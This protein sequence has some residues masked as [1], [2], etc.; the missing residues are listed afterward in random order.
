MIRFENV[1]KVYGSGASEVVALREAAFEI[2][3]GEFVCVWGASGSGK[4]TLLNIAG[5]IDSPTAGTVLVDGEDT[6]VLDGNKLADFRNRSIGYVFQSFNLIAVLSALENVMLPLLIGGTARKEA[7]ERATRL[8]VELGLA[9]EGARRPDKLSGGQRQR[10]AI[11]RA[12]VSEPKLVL[13]DEPTANLDSETSAETIELMKKMNVQRGVTFLLSTHDRDLATCA[14]RHLR[15]H[16]GTLQQTSPPQPTSVATHQTPVQNTD[17]CAHR[18][19][20][21]R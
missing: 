14:N 4:S 3:S 16:D 17:T 2:A 1:S 6:G 13:A 21:I 11:A 10:V 12:L 20:A 7:R 9:V 15:L 18:E 5:L 19:Q 8:L